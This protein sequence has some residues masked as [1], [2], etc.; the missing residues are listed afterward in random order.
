MNGRNKSENDVL[1]LLAEG[2]TV[3]N[4][5]DVPGPRGLTDEGAPSADE[6]KLCA[7]LTARYSDGKNK[8]AVKIEIRRPSESP[9][10]IEIQP[11]QDEPLLESMRI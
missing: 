5:V 10:T 8:P 1:E 4:C 11:L 2:M 3:F 6:A 7:S 9:V